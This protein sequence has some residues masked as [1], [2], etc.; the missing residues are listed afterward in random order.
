MKNTFQKIFLATNVLIL[1]F[2]IVTPFIVRADGGPDIV[3][4]VLA[5][6]G[7]IGSTVTINSNGSGLSGYLNSMYILGISLCT[8]LA[9]LMIVIGGIEYMGSGSWGGKDEGRKRIDAAI[10]GLIVALGSYVILNSLNSSLLSTS[11]DLGKTVTTEAINTGSSGSGGLTGVGGGG[12]G[13]SI[14]G[15]PSAANYQGQTINSR[16]TYYSSTESVNDSNTM[17]GNNAVGGSLVVGDSSN[18]NIVG[19]VASNFY[20]A[21]TII[22]MQGSGGQTIYAVVDDNNIGASNNNL[23]NNSTFDVYT[24]Q[25]NPGVGKPNNGPVT[26]VYVPTSHLSN[27]QVNGLHNIN[28]L[29]TQISGPLK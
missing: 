8:G 17:A 25:K 20:P 21:G 18:P 27:S 29:Q 24:N 19:S 3:Y 12:S 9:V 7:N 14:W 1:A 22:S 28:N 15:D 11:L 10:I 26:I 4:K 5:P 16:F 2:L 6:I 23:N 13:S